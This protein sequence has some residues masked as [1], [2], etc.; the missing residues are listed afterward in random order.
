MNL[1]QIIYL[2][3]KKI[4]LLLVQ[5]FIKL[6]FHTLIALILIFNLRKIKIIKANKIKK[7]SHC[8]F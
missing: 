7:K 6:N 5:L 8:I 4:S 3:K 1:R 2:T